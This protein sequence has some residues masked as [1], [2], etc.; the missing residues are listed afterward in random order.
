MAFGG[1][2]IFSYSPRAG[3]AAADMANPVHGEAKKARSRA[4]HELAERH[5]RAFLAAHLGREFPVLWEGMRTGA[6]GRAEIHG[7]TPNYVRVGM[8]AERAGLSYQVTPAR[9]VAVAES[10]EFVWGNETA[11]G[12]D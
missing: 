2:H 3:T 4:L 11:A 1:I 10:G 8:A 7:Y 9:L 5:R 6:D 12:P